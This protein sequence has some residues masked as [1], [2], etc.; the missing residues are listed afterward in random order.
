MKSGFVFDIKRFSIHDGP[1]IRSTVFLKGCP[2]SCHWCHNPESQQSAPELILRPERCISCGTCIKACL[3]GAITQK[4]DTYLTNRSLCKVCGVCVDVCYADAREIVGKELAADKVLEEVLKDILFYKQSGG[5]VTFS[6]GEPL[7]QPEFLENLLQ[8]S[9]KKGLHTTLDTCGYAPW[10][11]ILRMMPYL[12]LI[13]YD[14]KILDDCLHKKYAGVSNKQ[15]LENLSS[16]VDYGTELVIR[17]P[18][19]PGINDSDKQIRELGEYLKEL[20]GISRVDLLPYHELSAGKY[21]RLDRQFKHD[22][23]RT[24]SLLKMKRIQDQLAEFELEVSIRG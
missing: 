11:V 12:D 22:N 15:I 7:H 18:V 5:G 10:D 23:W 13:L 19:L 14:I 6:G 2:L 17:Y 1:G 20:N 16:L 9:K 3:N 8:V 24:P 21:R 4:D